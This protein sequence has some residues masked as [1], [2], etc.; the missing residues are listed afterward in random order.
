MYL[1][2][3]ILR[4]D[5]ISREEVFRLLKG[6]YGIH[7][8]IWELFADSPNRFRDFLY[9]FE[10]DGGLPRIYTVSERTPAGDTDIWNIDTK[11]YDPNITEGQIL[12]FSL[13]ANP[14]ITRHGENDKHQRHDVVMDYKM[15]KRK[16]VTNAEAVQ[17]AGAAW[18]S[19]RGERLGFSVESVIAGGYRRRT[20]QK[21]NG[22]EVTIAT[23]DFDGVL[24]VSDPEILKQSLY[25][26]IGPAKGFG[27]GLMLVKPL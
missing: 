2:R 21:T 25:S 9:R 19:S 14:V 15:Q 10:T 22:S 23:L 12:R 1:S 17:E 11:I 8:M 5:S 7:A 13:R 26:G 24:T 16:M 6:E 20:F 4:P 3:A 27:C 18:I